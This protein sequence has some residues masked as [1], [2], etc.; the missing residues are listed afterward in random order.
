M[1][2]IKIGENG[3]RFRI[4][5]EYETW[6]TDKEYWVDKF[7]EIKD[8]YDLAFPDQQ[9][10]ADLRYKLHRWQMYV[11]MA[12][13][14]HNCDAI[15]VSFDYDTCTLYIHMNEELQKIFD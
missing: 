15:N 11:N 7:N 8:S 12:F 4:D 3:P 14:I 9:T 1:S 6:R 2:Q 5:N 10:L 13:N